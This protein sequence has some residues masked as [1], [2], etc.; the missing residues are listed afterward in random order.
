MLE[1]EFMVTSFKTSET[2][3]II[4][5]GLLSSG[6]EAEVCTFPAAQPF[7][8]RTPSSFYKFPDLR[9]T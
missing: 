3:P 7:A 4:A 2:K 6:P 8:S 5:Q 9:L 1:N